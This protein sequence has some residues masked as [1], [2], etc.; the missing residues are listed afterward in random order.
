MIIQID[1]PLLGPQKTYTSNSVVAGATL[2]LVDNNNDFASGDLVLYGKLGQEKTERIILTGVTSVNQLDH[3][4][5]PLFDHPVKTPLFQLPFD[6]AEVY[7]SESQGGTYTLLTTVNLSFDEEDTMYDDTDGTTSTWYKIRYKNSETNAVS[8]Y[9]DEVQGVGYTEDSLRSMSDEVL[10]DF[11]DPESKEITREQVRNWLN[12]GV[13]RVTAQAI[14][15]FPDYGGTSTTQALTSGT[16]NYPDNFLAFKRI[17]IGSSLSSSYPVLF[18]KE[19]ELNPAH[20]YSEYDPVVY[21][22]GNSWGV[23]PDCT[24]KTAYIYY[25]QHPS[26]MSND[27]D[28]HG[29]PYGGRDVLVAYALY[30]AWLG[31]DVEKARYFSRL[32]EDN[33]R[34]HMDFVAQSRQAGNNYFQRISIGAEEYGV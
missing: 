25:W 1:H 33:L 8:D 24:G 22:R 13:R 4:T 6:Q 23:N 21:L 14:R 17:N 27:A 12:A 20:E 18:K 32:Y 15:F 31:K 10:S 5:G 28:E 11:G 9:S 19:S 3:D 30:R 16:Y 26:A 2:T 7:S 29:L 34:E